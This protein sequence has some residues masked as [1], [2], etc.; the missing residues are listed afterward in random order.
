MERR[1]PLYIIPLLPIAVKILKWIFEDEEEDLDPRK[2]VNKRKIVKFYD[3]RG[4]EIKKKKTL[5]TKENLL[6]LFDIYYK[7]VALSKDIY[8]N[9]PSKDKLVKIMQ[10]E[11]RK[12]GEVLLYFQMILNY[13][14]YGHLFYQV[15]GKIDDRDN[16]R[17][18]FSRF[19]RVVFEY[20]TLIGKDSPFIINSPSIKNSPPFIK[21]LLDRLENPYYKVSVE[22]LDN[23][24]INGY[25]RTVEEIL[26]NF[27]I[28]RIHKKIRY[29]EDKV[30][31]IIEW[32]LRRRKIK[33]K[34]EKEILNAILKNPEDFDIREISLKGPRI[35]YIFSTAVIFEHLGED[36]GVCLDREKL[37]EL[38]SDMMLL[39]GFRNR[40]RTP[41][42][43]DERLRELQ[44]F[45]SKHLPD[46]PNYPSPE[47]LAII[48]GEKTLNILNLLAEMELNER[49]RRAS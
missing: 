42:S 38:W 1:V 18:D 45:V 8:K 32:K 4:Y 14:L 23:W 34:V 37:K 48:A 9:R 26:N 6:D 21:N 40:L 11:D 12:G 10:D 33:Y 17:Y 39:N 44:K 2:L 46:E 20:S 35:K 5:I 13:A 36:I 24:V 43:S 25:H 3:G 31:N 22:N 27:F 16:E 29:N 19:N 41:K 28:D 30:K 15:F 7:S 49:R 47:R